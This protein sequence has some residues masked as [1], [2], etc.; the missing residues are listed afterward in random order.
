[1]VKCP[2]SLAFTTD[3]IGHEMCHV[4]TLGR[5]TDTYFF[6]PLL[7]SPLPRNCSVLAVCSCEGLSWFVIPTFYRV[8]QFW[9]YIRTFGLFVTSPSST[10]FVCL[11]LGLKLTRGLFATFRQAPVCPYCPMLSLHST[12][13][14]MI[15]NIASKIGYDQPAN[16]TGNTFLRAFV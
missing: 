5:S 9:R 14:L 11:N 8:L 12:V 10:Y 15:I 6:D 4:W 13:S 16:N 7:R 2:S 1:M 3:D